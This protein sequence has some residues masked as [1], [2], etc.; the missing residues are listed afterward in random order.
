MSSKVST[1]IQMTSLLSTSHHFIA[2]KALSLPSSIYLKDKTWIDFS[3][4]NEIFF[5]WECRGHSIQF[6]MTPRSMMELF[7]KS[8]EILPLVRLILNN[9]DSESYEEVP[10]KKRK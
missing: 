9:E 6:A 1:F 4:T 2:M 7:K 8:G 10:K 3:S 5:F